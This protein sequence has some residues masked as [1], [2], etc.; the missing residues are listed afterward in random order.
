MPRVA[1]KKKEYLLSDFS[2]WVIG[3]MKTLGYTQEQMGAKIGIGQS[4]FSEKLRQKKFTL[5]DV[6]T[7][8]Q[9]LDASDNEI[10]RL[11]RM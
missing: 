9:V 2:E 4:S 3:R 7:I 11:M 8:L 5:A 10:V 6:I 1:I